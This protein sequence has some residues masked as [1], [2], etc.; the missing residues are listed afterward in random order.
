MKILNESENIAAVINLN[1][2]DDII[3][4]LSGISKD[5]FDEDE[6]VVTL[7]LTESRTKLDKMIKRLTNKY[8]GA[9]R[10]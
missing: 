9:G 6:D 5:D 8:K 10:R 2:L 1:Q 3:N 7:T 4:L